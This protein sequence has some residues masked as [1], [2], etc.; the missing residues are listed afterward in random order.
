MCKSVYG[1][2][3]RAFEDITV[4]YDFDTFVRGYRPTAADR[5]IQK[6]FSVDFEVRSIDGKDRV[7]TR[8][9]STISDKITWNDWVQM[10]PSLRDPLVYPAHDVTAVPTVATNNDYDDFATRVVST[11]LRWWW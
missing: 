8:S 1:D 2:R 7:F 5:H 4:A 3:L 9:K 10:Y 6:H 11:L